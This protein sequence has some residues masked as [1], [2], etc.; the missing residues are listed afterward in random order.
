[1]TTEQSLPKLSFSNIVLQSN[2]TCNLDCSYCYIPRE[3]RRSKDKM[4]IE[5]VEKV[6]DM[7]AKSLDEYQRLI[8][9]V[10]HAGEPLALGIELFK[11]YLNKFENL[12]QKGLIR[13]SV[14]TNATLINDKWC[15][16]FIDFDFLVGVSI[17]GGE[18]FNY[19]RTN[20]AGNDVTN[21]IER[22]I[23]KLKQY[24]IPFTVIAVVGEHN[25]NFA[26]EVYDYFVK[27]G[28][29]SVGFNIEEREGANKGNHS[30][31]YESSHKFWSDL[32]S[33]WFL[34]PAIR[35]REINKCL[36][37]TK[38]KLNELGNPE[39]RRPTNLWPTVD[40]NGNVTIISPE[41]ASIS[42]EVEMKKF[43]IGEIDNSSILSRIGK[44]N[45]I[46]FV[47]DI[48]LGKEKCKNEC[49]YYSFCGGGEA[50]NKYF[51]NNDL[52]STET[53]HCINHRKS[54]LD[55][56]IEYSLNN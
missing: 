52:T 49:A 45:E 50:S 41:F 46:D 7:L 37:W 26:K 24:K 56:F 15:Q 9:V 53:I 18:Q 27:L 39:E 12:R 55:S 10:W 43:I 44:A 42:D 19:K 28:C 1:M 31:N 21:I 54:L 11:E 22:G 35:V 20:W 25:F 13:H 29:H 8:T 4:S 33:A 47:K 51:E 38:L 17:D 14:Q 16:L 36:M 5:I 23:N 3:K 30:I 48:I 2:T 6:V 34:N 32:I 40:I